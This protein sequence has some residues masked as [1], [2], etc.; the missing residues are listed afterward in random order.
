M[1]F[2]VIDA[3]FGVAP[4]P[5]LGEQVTAGSLPPCR[6]AV[7]LSHTR[8]R[9][10]SAKTPSTGLSWFASVTASSSAPER[11]IW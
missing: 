4:N 3:S 1:A 5:G 11:A 7:A 2:F 9:L 10:P 6:V 8:G